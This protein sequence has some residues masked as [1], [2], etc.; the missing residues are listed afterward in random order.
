MKILTGK[1]PR[2]SE[3]MDITKRGIMLGPSQ[4]AIGLRIC[5]KIF[6][7]KGKELMLLNQQQHRKPEKPGQ[8]RQQ[9]RREKRDDVI[10]TVGHCIV[11]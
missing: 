11:Y 5:I 10:I 6:F 9:E 3:I 2:I 1:E 4:T 7:F 8:P